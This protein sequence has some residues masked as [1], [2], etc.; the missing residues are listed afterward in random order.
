MHPAA[1]PRVNA[2]SSSVATN[3]VKR[4][5]TETPFASNQKGRRPDSTDAFRNRTAHARRGSSIE[6]RAGDDGSRSS[7]PASEI[8]ST[9]LIYTDVERAAECLG[10]RCEATRPLGRN[11]RPRGDG[12]LRRYPIESSAAVAAGA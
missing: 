7:K 4:L 9:A 12:A 10:P 2:P 3:L 8:A 5:M 6:G 1:I 11:T